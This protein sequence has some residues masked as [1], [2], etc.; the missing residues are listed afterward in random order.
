MIKNIIFDLGKVLV[1]Y[2]FSR[3]FHQYGI[4]EIDR[5]FVEMA[6]IYELFNRGKISKQ[7]FLQ[8]LK[9]FLQTSQALSQIEA[10]WADLFTLN[11]KMCAL[12]KLLAP[13]YQIFI[14]SNTDEIHF[15][16]IYQKFPQ[17]H[18]FADNLLLSYQ[19]GAIKPQPAAYHKALQKFALRPEESLFIDDR[20]ENVNSAK[21]L[22]MAA[23]HHLNFSTTRLALSKVLERQDLLKDI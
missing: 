19:L 14:F 15:N 8:R 6:P 2:D 18:I 3:F 7:E 5:K 22:G 10:N 9:S 1:D 11:H 12:A 23:I 16:Y 21:V 4:E 13:D 17:L 20:I